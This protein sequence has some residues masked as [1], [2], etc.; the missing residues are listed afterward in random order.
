[1]PQSFAQIYLHIVFST[2]YRQPLILPEIEDK[3][4]AYIAGIIKKLGGIPIQINGMPDHIHILATLP[5]TITIAKYLEEIKRNSSRWIKTQGILYQ[6]FAWQN[7]YG[8][9]SVS[10]SQTN[11]VDR[12]I[13][14]QKVHHKRQDTFK[15][16]FEALLK[17]HNLE[18]EKEYLWKK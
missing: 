16:E 3:L 17:K 9:F 13:R 11:R 14:N 7:G 10:Q 4:Y 12:Y 5:R 2:K 6:H 8:A 15:R 18:Y 1:M